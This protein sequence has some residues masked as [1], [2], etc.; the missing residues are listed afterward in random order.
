MHTSTR[1]SSKNISRSHLRRCSPPIFSNTK[2][3]LSSS[4]GEI[5]T[6]GEPNLFLAQSFLICCICQCY[7][8][9]SVA[10]I[11]NKALRSVFRVFRGWAAKFFLPSTFSSSSARRELWR[12]FVRDEKKSFFFFIDEFPSSFI[13][14][15]SVARKV[16]NDLFE[17]SESEIGEILFC[18]RRKC[19]SQW[20][21]FLGIQ[22]RLILKCVKQSLRSWV[23]NRSMKVKHN[24]K[25]KQKA[26]SLLNN[27]WANEIRN[28]EIFLTNF[29]KWTFEIEAF[30]FQRRKKLKAEKRKTH[31]K[32]IVE[33]LF[34]LKIAL[35]ECEKKNLAI[36]FKGVFVYACL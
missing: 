14:Q 16:E 2:A 17:R 26:G 4:W 11:V 8:V 33:N 36:R 23:K 28:R 1:W 10:R 12:S 35:N 22:D 31:V 30:S 7:R 9:F 5:S 21:L 32:C 6:S 20:N 27:I 3:E 13:N 29:Y 18:N 25:R 15:S 34:S 24:L 19:G